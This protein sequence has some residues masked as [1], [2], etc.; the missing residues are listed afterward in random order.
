MTFNKKKRR[1]KNNGDDKAEK[2]TGSASLNEIIR[3]WAMFSLRSTTR[4][5]PGCWLIFEEIP[6]ASIVFSVKLCVPLC[7]VSCRLHSKLCFPIN[8]HSKRSQLVY[9]PS[10]RTIRRSHAV[11]A[12]LKPAKTFWQYYESSNNRVRRQTM[13]QTVPFLISTSNCPT[14][15]HLMCRAKSWKTFLNWNEKKCLTCVT[16][17]TICLYFMA[18]SFAQRFFLV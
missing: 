14:I 13:F 17:I 5:A 3:H 8:S 15:F 10:F 1:S 11:R 9:S 6:T 16:S 18:M 12:S 2:M 4:L 7:R